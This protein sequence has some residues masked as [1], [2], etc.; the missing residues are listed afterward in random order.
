[1]DE[2]LSSPI[3]T[4]VERVYVFRLLADEGVLD[5]LALFAARNRSE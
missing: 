2:L 1:M 5:N 4:Q 3:F